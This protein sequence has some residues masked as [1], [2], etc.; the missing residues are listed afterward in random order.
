MGATMKT[1]LIAMMLFGLTQAVC[2]ATI[3]QW[4]GSDGIEH[5]SNQPP[6]AGTPGQIYEQQGPGGVSDFS[7]QRN[8]PYAG[9]KAPT[10][11]TAPPAPAANSLQPVQIAPQ[12]LKVLTGP[13]Q[14]FHRF[15]QW[16]GVL[17][18][19]GFAIQAYATAFAAAF[20][21]RIGEVRV[22]RKLQGLARATLHDVVLPD[23][24]GGLTQVDHLALMPWGI[25]VIETKHRKGRI[26][27]GAK[28]EPWRARVGWRTYRFQNPLHQNDLHVRAVRALIRSVA[29]EGRVVFSG[30]AEFPEGMPQD[31]CR[32]G[33]LEQALSRTG[34]EM[35]DDAALT[36]AWTAV[37][38]A[39][40]RDRASRRRHL[41]TL[42]ERHGGMPR[43]LIGTI[44]LIAAA[45]LAVWLMF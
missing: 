17:L 25:V 34:R 6:P 33:Q 36:E 32:I 41:R 13:H 22:D 31:V 19:F 5:F 15:L 18:L 16:A 40:R 39:A 44:A 20:K 21:G 4:V 38:N 42:R 11:S 3:Y 1:L 9:A 45:T 27:G 43:V 26:Y 12:V 28:D 29:V 14:P 23:D 2:A 24:R 35:P 37:A 10:D 30:D 8:L 7:G